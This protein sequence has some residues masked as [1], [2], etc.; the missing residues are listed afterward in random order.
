MAARAEPGK[1]QELEPSFPHPADRPPGQHPKASDPNRLSDLQTHVAKL[2]GQGYTRAQ[3]AKTLVDHL[4]P[5][6]AGRPLEQRLSHARA[7]LRR[8]EHR[9][10]FR[11]EVYKQAVVKTDLALPSI[12]KGVVRTARRG[13]VDA[14]RLALEVTGRHNPRGEQQ[15]PN[16]VVAIN[17]IPRPQGE[18]VGEV[19]DQ[20]DDEDG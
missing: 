5:T 1:N 3:I 7:K 10:L 15:A 4:A 2:Y 13:R 14:A 16:V 12:L 17:G 18:P 8:W 6:M 9:E 11:D 19:I 20:V